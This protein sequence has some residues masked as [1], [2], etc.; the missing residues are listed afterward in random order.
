MNL[1]SSDVFERFILSLF[2][3]LANKEETENETEYTMPLDSSNLEELSSN[4]EEL[5]ADVPDP[6]ITEIRDNQN[7]KLHIGQFDSDGNITIFLKVKN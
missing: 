2:D 1:D 3:N 6:I 4:L 5:Y 7:P